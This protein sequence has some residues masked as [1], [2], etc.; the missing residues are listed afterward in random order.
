M[1]NI[2]RVDAINSGQVRII[3]ETLVGR[4]RLVKFGEAVVWTCETHPFLPW[5]NFSPSL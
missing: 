1:C 2:Y 5:K 4:Y 3:D